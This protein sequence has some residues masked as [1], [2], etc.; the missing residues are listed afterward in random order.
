MNL[1][2]ARLAV[3]FKSSPNRSQNKCML[4]PFPIR[5]MFKSAAL[6]DLTEPGRG[7][8]DFSSLMPILPNMDISLRNML[9]LWSRLC[10]LFSIE[11]DG[12]FRLDDFDC[13]TKFTMA[14]ET[15][16]NVED[17]EIITVDD[18]NSE[19]DVVESVGCTLCIEVLIEMNY[20]HKNFLKRKKYSSACYS[21]V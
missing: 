1:D 19:F 16:K 15:E 2:L 5:M 6:L 9:K 14:L 21:L 11:S 7:T 13:S 12:A 18:A 20:H 17:V 4:S 8:V 10:R 3:E